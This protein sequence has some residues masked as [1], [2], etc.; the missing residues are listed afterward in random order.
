MKVEISASRI[1]NIIDKL[2]EMEGN[3]VHLPFSCS[4]EIRALTFKKVFIGMGVCEWV[5]CL[6]IV[7]HPKK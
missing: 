1:K 5:L 7:K 2:P 6:D 4:G 3:E